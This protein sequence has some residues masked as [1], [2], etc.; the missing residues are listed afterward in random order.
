[1]QRARL[2]HADAQRSATRSMV[3]GIARRRKRGGDER[4]QQREH[5]R[6][7]KHE[8]PEPGRLRLARAGDGDDCGVACS[9]VLVAAVTLRR[10]SAGRARGAYRARCNPA[11]W[12]SVHRNITTLNEPITMID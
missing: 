4:G 3:G 12:L 10:L 1:M 7:E 2:R 11:S 5:P 8:D 6:C 9:A